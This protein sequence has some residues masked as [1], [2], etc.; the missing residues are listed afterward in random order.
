MLV[1]VEVEY[2]VE[3]EVGDFFGSLLRGLYLKFLVVI[4]GVGGFLLDLGKMIE[5]GKDRNENLKGL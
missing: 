2:G 5:I 4:K 1:W 3:V